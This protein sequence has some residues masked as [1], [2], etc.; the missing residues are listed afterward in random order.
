MDALALNVSDQLCHLVD[1]LCIEDHIWQ[2]GSCLLGVD[3]KVMEHLGRQTAEREVDQSLN[4]LH[5]KA[6]CLVLRLV[7]YHNIR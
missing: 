7:C 5:L 1:D 3:L 2:A 6:D 4:A